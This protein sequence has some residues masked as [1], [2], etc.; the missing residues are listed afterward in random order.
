MGTFMM[1]ISRRLATATLVVLVGAGVS[2]L[3]GCQQKDP[4]V[5]VTPYVAKAPQPPPAAASQ[6]AARLQ[7]ATPAYEQAVMGK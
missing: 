1:W 4:Q 5:M 3:A 2:G 7:P 6:P